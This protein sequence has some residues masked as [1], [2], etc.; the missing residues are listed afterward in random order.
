VRSLFTPWSLTPLGPATLR[1]VTFKQHNHNVAHEVQRYIRLKVYNRSVA[2]L[3]CVYL[4]AA[5]RHASVRRTGRR[6]DAGNN[7]KT[8]I[9]DG[10]RVES[11]K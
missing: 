9:N 4:P 6:K 7:G 1:F 8:L 5:G 11:G 10:W 3:V 2:Q